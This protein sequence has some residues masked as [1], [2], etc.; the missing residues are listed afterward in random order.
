MRTNN[1]SAVAVL[2]TSFLSKKI[3]RNERFLSASILSNVEISSQ[4]NIRTLF[5]STFDS[6]YIYIALIDVNQ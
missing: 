1:K 2:E 4:Q 3:R 6:E 5:W